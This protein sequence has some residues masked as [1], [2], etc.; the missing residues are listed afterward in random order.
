MISV[1]FVLFV[2]VSLIVFGAHKYLLRQAEAAEP[3]VDEIEEFI[4]I[5]QMPVLKAEDV[6]SK[7]PV[8]SCPDCGHKNP[9]DADFCIR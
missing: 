8:L 7:T 6:E 9:K 1:S 3:V 4:D 2:S 5:D